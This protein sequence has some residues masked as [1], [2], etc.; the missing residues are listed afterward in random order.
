MTELL[1]RA[2][3][4]GEF[5]KY[6][7]DLID[8][9]ADYLE[10]VTRLPANPYATPEESLEHFRQVLDHR[11]PPHQLFGEVITESVHL[12]HPEYMGH[13]VVPP[14]PLAA[15]S[16]LVS[17]MLNTG[18]AIFE[19]GRP[20]TVMEKLVIE[21][22][23]SLLG[24]AATAD[25]FLTSGGSLANLTALLCARAKFTAGDRPCL[26]VSEHAHYC[27]QRAVRVMG[28]GEEGIIYLP[29]DKELRVRVDEIPRLVERARQDG[30]TPIALVGSACTTATGT[31]DP[32]DKMAAIAQD[33][34]LWFH[35]DGAHGAA[36]RLSPQHR[37]L[38]DGLELADSV[39]LD[40][41][42][43]LM[44][45]AIT[46]GLFF[47][48]GKDAYRTFH[49]RAEYLLTE[50]IDEDWSNIAK[51]SFECTKRMLSL[52]VYSL[53]STYGPQIFQ[54]YVESVAQIGKEMARLVRQNPDLELFME[55]DINIVCFRFNHVSLQDISRNGINE[56]IR[57]R[58]TR[59]GQTYIV[60]TR[61]NEQVYLRCTLTNPFTTVGHLEKA[62]LKVVSIGHDLVALRQSIG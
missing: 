2:Y 40:F 58:L 5:R 3:S 31:Y 52:R 4:P 43:M 41:H 36:V 42:K 47:R 29:T 56:L 8:Q 38:A 61:I 62:L 44:V 24:L 14:A 57:D 49:Q 26:L 59:S 30:L 27:I 60:Q 23:A 19:L 11:T 35:V 18:M 12:H 33:C 13:Q 7:H 25:G 34:G 15:L 46:T 39:T 55:P 21:R 16:D 17:S 54:D 1:T 20:G 28:W 37:H 53:L 22:F 9:L 6:G 32:L 50:G 51:R 45:P 10:N 48:E